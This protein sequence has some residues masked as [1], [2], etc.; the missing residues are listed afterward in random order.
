MVVSKHV[1][2]GIPPSYGHG[3][4]EI[5]TNLILG[6]HVFKETQLAY[7]DPGILEPSKS[8]RRGSYWRNCTQE[9][10]KKYQETLVWAK[11]S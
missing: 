1:V 7:A 5:M 8:P 3:H 6:Y 9:T 10:I 11:K 2:Y 4:G